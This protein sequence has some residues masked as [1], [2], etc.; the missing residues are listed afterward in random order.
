[1]VRGRLDTRRGPAEAG[2]SVD[3][4]GF[5]GFPAGASLA[6]AALLLLAACTPTHRPVLESAAVVAPPAPNSAAVAAP[7]SPAPAP[8]ASATPPALEKPKN[9]ED[10]LGLAADALEKLFGEPELVRRDEPA[11]VWQY[12]SSSCVVD[13]YLYPEQSDYRVAYIEARDHSA[14]SMTPGNCLET[15]GKPAI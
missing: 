15:L 9:P 14:A 13:L 6:V 2:S 8:S 11:E 3:S 7:D 5:R 10:V 12:R 1:M 4:P